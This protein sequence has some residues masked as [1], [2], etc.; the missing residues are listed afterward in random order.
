MNRIMVCVEHNPMITHI[1]TKIYQ[2]YTKEVS[3]MTIYF[4]F[5]SYTSNTPRTVS[6]KNP[7][8]TNFVTIQLNEQ[9]IPFTRNDH[10][11]IIHPG[12]P[13]GGFYM[14]PVSVID[15]T[16]ITTSLNSDIMNNIQHCGGK[17]PDR[18]TKLYQAFQDAMADTDEDDTKEDFNHD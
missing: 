2:T 10:K 5:T 7:F 1:K 11:R 4:D 16:D 3:V 17:T 6:I 12:G 18:T 15:S 13:V 9:H 14:E 8:F